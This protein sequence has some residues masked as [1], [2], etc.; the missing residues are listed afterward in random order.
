MNRL[1]Q[2]ATERLSDALLKVRHD[3]LPG[4]NLAFVVLPQAIA[5]SFLAGVPPHFG[6]YCAIYGVLFV[7]L[8]NPAFDFHGGP[9][10]SVSVAIGVALLPF[11]PRFGA[12][13]MGY[14]LSLAVM[15]GF[16]QLLFATLK[17]LSRL[18]DFMS[19]AVVSGMI[20][21]IGLFLIF[22]S[23]AP[24]GGLPLNMQVH[25]HL[26]ITWQT[27]LAV[28]EYGNP[29][30]IEVG[31]ITLFA[32]IIAR[33][34]GALKKW[35]LLVGLLFGTFYSEFLNSSHGGLMITRLE[36]V[37]NIHLPLM[38]PSLP[39]FNPEA[40]PDLLSLI[41]AAF[42]IALL[43]LFQTVAIVRQ[44]SRLQGDYINVRQACLADAVSNIGAGFISSLPGCGSFNRVALLRSLG[45]VSRWGAVL[46]ALLLFVMIVVARD[47]VAII[48]L[49]SMA[50][51]IMLVGANMLRVSE[52]K[53]HFRSR[54][55]TVVFLS[56]F[57]SVHV[58][59]LLDAVLISAGFA[60]LNWI[61]HKSHPHIEIAD[62]RVFINGDMYYASVP[63][64]EPM[65][66]KLLN[67]LDSIEIDLTQM[68]HLDVEAARWLANLGKGRGKMVQI[69]L[70]PSQVQERR[71]LLGPAG[72]DD[73]RL[74]TA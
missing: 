67:R 52:I 17:P 32:A 22:K 43:G 44:S 65:I 37:G 47:W 64:V 68:A 58:F 21:G 38:I 13:Y 9:N 59:G 27:F 12:D 50:A 70:Y 31:F 56:A 14:V 55:E 46:S 2:E 61:W 60:L 41:P 73:A 72:L 29:F 34:I 45:V 3:W 19:E 66:S 40:L 20:F 11:A 53:H 39:T 6:I 15:V 49:P 51:V 36:Q 30:A 57:I 16:F 1:A 10:S 5:F 18:L 54:I 28:M 7:A 74:V 23:F 24:F 26:Q 8:L 71:L 62:H 33:Q 69:R 4:L 63:T 35:Y 25:W 42:A 48:P